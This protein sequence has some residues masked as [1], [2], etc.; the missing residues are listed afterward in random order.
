VLLALSEDSLLK[1]IA[2]HYPVEHWLFGGSR[3]PADD[4]AAFD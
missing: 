1:E 2:N 4:Q 3:I